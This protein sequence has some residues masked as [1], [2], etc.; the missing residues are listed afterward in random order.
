MISVPQ[1]SEI[2]KYLPSLVSYFCQSSITRHAI[3]PDGYIDSEVILP[4]VAWINGLRQNSERS[5]LEYQV[6][7]DPNGSLVAVICSI[8]FLTTGPENWAVLNTDI[9]PTQASSIAVF[10]RKGD[11]FSATVLINHVDE[12]LTTAECEVQHASS[13]IPLRYLF[14]GYI[15]QPLSYHYLELDKEGSVTRTHGAPNDPHLP[16]PADKETLPHDLPEDALAHIRAVARRAFPQ[17]AQLLNCSEMVSV[18]L[19]EELTLSEGT[20]YART[21]SCRIV[22]VDGQSLPKDAPKKFCLKLFDD[23]ARSVGSDE[24]WSQNFY[25]AEDM[26]QNEIDVYNRLE[27]AWGSVVPQF[28][29]THSES[30]SREP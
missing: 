21:F 8:S 14:A 1:I 7:I 4:I 24:R 10:R 6:K 16:P 3:P 22:T 29:G 26:T 20:A 25:T 12:T 23:S 30:Q 28:Y 17:F 18:L 15:E 13:A 2:K 9:C 19:E 5:V 27:F 11:H